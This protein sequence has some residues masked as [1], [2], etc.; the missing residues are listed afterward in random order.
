MAKQADTAI[1]G[2]FNNLIYYKWRDV[3]CVRVKGNTGKQAPV[4]IQQAGIL[5][6][7]SGISAKLRALLKPVIPYPKDRKLMY[8][9]NNAIQQWLRAA[10][11]KNAAPINEIAGL[12]GFSFFGNPELTNGFRAAMPVSKTADGNLSIYIPA[13]DSPNPISPLPFSGNIRLHIMAASC[14]VNDNSYTNSHEILLDIP[15]Y[16][17][18]I[19]P[20][21]IPIPLQT[22]PGNLTVVALN[23]N[24]LNA[25]IVAA[26][27]N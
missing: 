22:L 14:N 24:D 8:R 25:G 6:K 1:T 2:T 21:Q 15:Y 19:P 23:I 5:G 18:P 3:Y 13:F 20:Q 11:L 17:I 7:A 10:D 9:M 27:W 12:N 26:M 16:G 4:A